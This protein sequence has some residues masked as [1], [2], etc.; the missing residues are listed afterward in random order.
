LTSEG[1]SLFHNLGLVWAIVIM[2]LWI[3]TLI[4]FLGLDLA[5][6]SPLYWVTIVLIRTF[7]HTGLFILAHDAMHGSLIPKSATINQGLGRLCLGL[8]A[9][10]PYDR[11]KTNHHQHH[12]NPGQPGD[13]DFHNG[14]Q[15]HPLFWYFQF[16]GA[17]VSITQMTVFVTVIGCSLA[18]AI[19]LLH[20]SV[21]NCILV[22]M[23]PLILSS[24]Q[25]FCFG[26]YFPHRNEST[27]PQST[28]YPN[29]LSLLICYHFS[30]HQEHHLFPD[31]A[32]YRL[33]SCDTI[34]YN[35]I[36]KTIQSNN[37]S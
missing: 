28:Y 25:L 10:L 23:V 20:V 30:Y 33:P 19:F 32:W 35:K 11:C 7:F 8:Y 37:I 17:Y 22:W 12:Q 13:P 34:R 26:T 2:S 16:L 9:V 29:L 31:V 3:G 1:S 14:I 15:T 36:R 5:A 18:I 27:G 4:I 21:T 6:L 24:L